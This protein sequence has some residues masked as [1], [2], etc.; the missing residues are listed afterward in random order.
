MVCLTVRMG[1]NALRDH[2]S[3]EVSEAREMR[4]AYIRCAPVMLSYVTVSVRHK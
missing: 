1:L 2:Y 4:K 3:Q